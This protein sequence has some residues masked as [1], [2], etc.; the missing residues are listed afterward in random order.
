MEVSIVIWNDCGFK[1][2]GSFFQDS[3]VF[4][5]FIFFWRCLLKFKCFSFL[6]IILSTFIVVLILVWRFFLLACVIV[7]LLALFWQLPNL[8]QHRILVS[9]IV[10][11]NVGRVNLISSNHY[12]STLCAGISLECKI[13]TGSVNLSRRSHLLLHLSKEECLMIVHVEDWNGYEVVAC[14]D[15]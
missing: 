14:W 4:W 3:K 13:F 10:I 8:E 12:L 5:A 7:N 6:F 15:N 2:W 1:S 9:Y 11:L